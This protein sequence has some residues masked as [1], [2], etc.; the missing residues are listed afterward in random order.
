MLLQKL[1][2]TRL[3]SSFQ[4]QACT[5]V[6]RNASRLQI[7]QTRQRK[8]R[9]TP[10]ESNKLIQLV[11]EKGKAWSLLSK[12]FPDRLPSSLLT[13]YRLLAERGF[14]VNKKPE[15]KLPVGNWSD[16]DTEKLR[17]LILLHGCDWDIVEENFPNRTRKQ[18]QRRWQ[19]MKL[20]EA[21]LSSYTPEENRSIIDAVAKYGTQDFGKIREVTNNW[22]TASQLE[23]HYFNELDPALNDSPWTDEEAW[24]VYYLCNEL[25]GEMVRVQSRLRK[26]RSLRAMWEQFARIQELVTATNQAKKEDKK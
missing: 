9:W 25:D 19:Q 26:R 3:F 21:D 4:W 8:R 10:E 17:R 6:I 11:N 15:R 22:R 14:D 23:Q 13:H 5:C 16:A 2:K 20:E 24:N 12:E 18:C 7:P 1:P